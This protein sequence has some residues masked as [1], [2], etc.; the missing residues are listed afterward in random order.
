MAQMRD[1]L[2]GSVEKMDKMKAAA[3][4]AAAEIKQ[5]REEKEK[6]PTPP[7]STYL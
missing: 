1:L 4:E 2:K 7:K 5:E 6:A 3:K